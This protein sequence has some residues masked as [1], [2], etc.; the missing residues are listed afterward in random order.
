MMKKFLTPVRAIRMNCYWCCLNQWIEVKFCPASKCPSWDYRLGKRNKQAPYTPIKTIRK[1]CLK[2][3]GY[4]FKEIK[5]CIYYDCSLYPYR[6]G[7][8]PKSP[9][10]ID[11]QP[12]KSISTQKVAS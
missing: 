2:C 12:L 11:K 7:K 1:H 5:N 10:T 8:R 9:K 4:I 3:S 6:M